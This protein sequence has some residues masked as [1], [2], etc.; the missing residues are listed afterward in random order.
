MANVTLQGTSFANNSFYTD[1][2]GL[3]QGMAY[4]EPDTR[5]RYRAGK[6]A[7][8]DQ[9]VYYGGLPVTIK[10]T[11]VNSSIIPT[12]SLAKSVDQISGF[13]IF[14]Q[15]NNLILVG[16]SE[17][18]IMTGGGTINT[19]KLGTKVKVAVVCDPALRTKLNNQ[20]DAV[21]VTWDF[22][23]N[24]LV[25]ATGSAVPLNV[26]L[27]DIGLSN[28]R[29]VKATNGTYTWSENGNCALIEI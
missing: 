28:S 23:A 16:A 20:I 25:E 19:V 5:Y 15:S 21:K 27:L 14:N 13:T 10:V 3:M 24:M 17:V 26:T 6:I 18:G 22:T 12:I 29:V 1:S 7:S 9:D 2:T 8:T 4:D 11:A